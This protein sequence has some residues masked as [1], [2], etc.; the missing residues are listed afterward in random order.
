M[1]RRLGFGLV[2]VGLVVAI[3]GTALGSGALFT[4]SGRH[5]I[6]TAPIV[7]GTPLH[8]VVAAK[9]GRRY[10]LAVQVVFDRAG[11]EEEN[12]ALVVDAQ[13]PLVASLESAK[14]SGVLDP[15]V[16][17]N[18]LYG[19]SANPNVRAPR[20]AGPRELVAERLVGPWIATRDGD[21]ACEVGLELDRRGRARITEARIIVYDDRLPSSITTTLA[22]AGAGLISL[23]SGT[24]LVLFGGRRAGRGGAR[25]RPIV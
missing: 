9:A 2:I 5:P 15:N 24:I 20:G 12:G 13:L 23:V 6:A 1:R 11:L 21:A 16:P 3:V 18:V 7:L 19:Q 4:F 25:R 17:P 22:V 14:V 8:Q 10:T